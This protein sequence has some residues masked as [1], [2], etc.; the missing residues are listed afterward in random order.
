MTS[1][2]ILSLSKGLY[3]EVPWLQFVYLNANVTNNLFSLSQA[4]M[5]YTV[6][7]PSPN[8]RAPPTPLHQNLALTLV[9]YIPYLDSVS[10]IILCNS[11]SLFSSF[12]VREFSSSLRDL[13]M[14]LYAIFTWFNYSN[15][16]TILQEC[17][18]NDYSHAHMGMSAILQ[19]LFN[20]Y[21]L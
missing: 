11:S 4:L 2:T 15:N 20:C 9:L 10:V 17:Q 3:L 12:L 5:C 14:E 21:I 16:I 13:S 8:R 6:L 1:H 18:N 19:H 7:S